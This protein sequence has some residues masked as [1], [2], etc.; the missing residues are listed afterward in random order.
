MI[1]IALTTEFAIPAGSRGDGTDRVI[2][3]SPAGAVVGAD[4]LA[5]SVTIDT[6]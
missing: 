5:S 6:I 4:P 2:R 3:W 1:D